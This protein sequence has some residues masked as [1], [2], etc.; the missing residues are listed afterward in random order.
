MAII[1][2]EDFNQLEKSLTKR[3]LQYGWGAKYYFPC[4]PYEIAIAPLDDYTKR[5]KVGFVF[6]YNE[7]SPKLI[8]LEVKRYN[9]S[10]L[11]MCEREGLMCEREGYPPFL[12]SDITFENAVF[13]HSKIGSYFERD[14]ADKELGIK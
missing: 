5:L 14:D 7:N 4:C 6:A 11:V 3:S 2:L 12:I 10:I 9:S 13:V 1:D 8:I